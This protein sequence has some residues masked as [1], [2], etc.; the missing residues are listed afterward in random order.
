QV[1]YPAEWAGP[2][3]PYRT[4]AETEFKKRHLALVKT[5]AATGV[6]VASAQARYP[7][8]IFSPAWTGRRNQNTVQAEELAS[9]GFVVVGIDHPYG[10]DLTIFPDGRMARTTLGDFL[11]C[12]TDE[13]VQESV[14]TAEAQLRI[15]AADV[16]FVLDEL[17]RLDR[18]DLQDIL[19]GRLDTSRV[20]IFGHSFG[21]A[22]AAE[23]CLIDAR[24]QAGINLDGLIFGEPT[25]QRIGKPFLFLCD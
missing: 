16:C 17:E 10:T 8:V 15:R 18:S 11:D 2:G 22:V 9:H 3:R 19:T 14:R 5:N 6:P 25:R 21:G 7:V 20:G 23:V 24:F 4:P 1:W 13:T 12:A